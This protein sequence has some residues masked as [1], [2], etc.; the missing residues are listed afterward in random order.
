MD[1]FSWSVIIIT[2]MF[3]GLYAYYK[4]GEKNSYIKELV[5]KNRSLNDYNLRMRESSRLQTEELAYLAEVF[6]E[7]R[8]HRERLQKQL[9][10]DAAK[11]N[12][13]W[14]DTSVP[15]SIKRMFDN[16]NRPDVQNPRRDSGKD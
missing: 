11:S 14:L 1:I 2:Y 12:K 15:D 9:L 3:S 13:E 16:K 4:I 8:I 5:E 6:G 10:A 7:D